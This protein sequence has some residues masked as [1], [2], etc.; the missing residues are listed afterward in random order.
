V[1]LVSAALQGYLL[2]LGDLGRGKAAWLVRSLI[3]LAGL[4]LALPAGGLFGLSQ[5]LLLSLALVFL[6]AGIGLRTLMRPA[7]QSA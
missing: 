3:G 1:A 5:W 6:L 4:T 2:G 7:L